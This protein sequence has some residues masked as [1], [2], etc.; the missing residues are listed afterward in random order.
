MCQDRHNGGS[1]VTISEISHIG[2]VLA[3]SGNLDAAIQEFQSA[4][5]LNPQILDA[6]YNL[7]LV[8][9]IKGDLGAAIKEYETELQLNPKNVKALGRLESARNQLRLT[10]GAKTITR[11]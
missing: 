8:F 6:H 2:L 9:A 7:G 5:Q 10:G 3:R 11:P 1:V 4:L